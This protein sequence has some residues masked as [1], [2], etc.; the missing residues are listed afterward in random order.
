MMITSFMLMALLIFDFAVSTPMEM[1]AE[2]AAAQVANQNFIPVE[3]GSLKAKMDAAVRLGRASARSGKYWTGYQFNVKPGITVDVEWQGKKGERSSTEKYETRNL[4]IFFLREDESDKI[5]RVE[6]YNLERQ[7]DFNGYPVYWLGRATN[8]ESFARLKELID[9]DATEKVGERA[10]MALA[11]HDDSRIGQMLESIVRN[12]TAERIRKS[13]V[14]W[15]GQT[16]GETMFLSELVRNDQESTEIRKQAAFAIGVSQDAQALTALQ[17]LYSQVS[18]R[19]VKKQVIFGAFVNNKN[20]DAAVDFLIQIAEKETDRETRKQ[21][22]FWLGQKAGQRSLEVLGQTVERTDED[23]EVQKQAVFAISQRKKD[24]SVPMLV[25]LA[26]THPK[27]EVRKQALFW[28]GQ[29][30]DERAL[31]LF[32]EIL[33]K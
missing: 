4:G 6:V 5:T 3:G 12:S 24:E 31:E 21:A 20:S 33:S 32:K 27:P 15:L 14:F 28:L 19:E 26:K 16:E 25:K 23:T 11:I 2:P 22:I 7:H 30:D 10:T 8:D 17:N 1:P 9:R 29:V 18:N 13:A